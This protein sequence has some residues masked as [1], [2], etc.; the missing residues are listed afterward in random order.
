MSS[1]RGD[2]DYF[3]RGSDG[4]VPVQSDAECRLLS[5]RVGSNKFY[6]LIDEVIAMEVLGRGE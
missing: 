1:C 2:C 3:L 4:W 6:I 5:V